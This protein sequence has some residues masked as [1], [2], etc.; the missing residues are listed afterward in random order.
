[1]TI[2]LRTCRKAYLI[3]RRDGR[4]LEHKSHDIKDIR[5]LI[6]ISSRLERASK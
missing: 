4:I 1:M 6:Q 5:R 3:R 2:D